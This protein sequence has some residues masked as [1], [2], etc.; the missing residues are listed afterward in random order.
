MPRDL[1]SLLAV[2]ISAGFVT[3]AES[4]RIPLLH[5]AA[6]GMSTMR[7]SH[8]VP[9]P[10]RSGTPF[11]VSLV[12]VALLLIHG[13]ITVTITFAVAVAVF[14]AQALWHGRQD[15]GHCAFTQTITGSRALPTRAT[16]ATT[17]AAIQAAVGPSDGRG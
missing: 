8:S 16:S 7:S 11:G 17:H 12:L 1:V 5:R 13:T 3:A 6:V 14:A 4:A 2:L 10:R 9:T 15:K